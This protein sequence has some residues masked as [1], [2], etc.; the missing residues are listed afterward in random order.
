MSKKNK[1]PLSDGHKKILR[2]QIIS[3]ARNYYHYLSNK[4]FKIVCEDGTEVNV[5]FF[6]SD[7]K[8]MTGLYSDLD[9]EDFFENCLTGKID[10]GNIDTLQK[11]NW[12]TLKAKGQRIEKIHELLYK[13]SQKTLLLETLETNTCIFPYAIK[14]SS[15]NICVGF[16]TNVN[17]A[18][19]LRK[20]S[21]A[22]KAKFEKNIIAIFA[23]STK[24]SLY[25]ELVYISNVLGVYEKNADLLNKL[26]DDIQMKFLELVTRPRTE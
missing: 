9:E 7:F 19:S 12:G 20:A 6:I 3:G 1:Y 26:D 14:N 13:D 2:N 8:H 11:Y 25:H 4:I 23:K 22:I 21:S 15:S 10:V 17:K 24:N 5:R 16:V 18:R